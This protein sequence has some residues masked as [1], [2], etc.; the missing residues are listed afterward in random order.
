MK[1]ITVHGAAQ[2][3]GQLK[4]QENRF[5]TLPYC[6]CNPTGVGALNLGPGSLGTSEHSLGPLAL[7]LV[8]V[9]SAAGGAVSCELWSLNKAPHG[10]PQ[11]K[12]GG[13]R[14]ERAPLSLWCLWGCGPRVRFSGG[15]SQ[16]EDG[17]SD[18]RDQEG[19]VDLLEGLAQAVPPFQNR[20]EG[21]E[22]RLVIVPL[23]DEP[24]ASEPVVLVR[25]PQHPDGDPS[26]PSRRCPLRIRAS[27]CCPPPAGPAR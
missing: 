4:R 13:H 22:E 1:K 16:E 25:A 20:L 23:R 3:G 17:N 18:G 21:Q 8:A 11:G 9:S 2:R 12:G 27:G 7:P 14:G 5:Y 19:L 6:T 26:P 10:W 24:R 15:V